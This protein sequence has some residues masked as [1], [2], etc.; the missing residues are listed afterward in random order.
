MD[1]CFQFL[2]ALAF[3]VHFRSEVPQNNHIYLFIALKS[4]ERDTAKDTYWIEKNWKHF[5]DNPQSW[6]FGLVSHR[7]QRNETVR[8]CL[9]W[10]VGDTNVHEVKIPDHRDILMHT[11][12][13]PP[14]LLY[15]SYSI[16]G[17]SEAIYMRVIHSW[18]RHTLL[19]ILLVCVCVYSFGVCTMYISFVSGMMTELATAEADRSR[20]Y[21]IEKT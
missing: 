21:E 2:L 3:H 18:Q 16:Y 12:Q 4:N 20:E 10:N 14:Y 1:G 6:N 9:P 15:E 8:H 17:G 5:L 11:T 19:F 13:I 7:I